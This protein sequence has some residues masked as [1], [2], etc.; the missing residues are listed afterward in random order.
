M[1][2]VCLPHRFSVQITSEP[3]SAHSQTQDCILRKSLN[4][5]P[6]HHKEKSGDMGHVEVSCV[7]ARSCACVYVFVCA[8]VCVQK[9]R[10][11]R[12]KAIYDCSADNPD[13]LTFREGEVIVVEGE[14][15]SEWWVSWASREDDINRSF[16]VT[17]WQSG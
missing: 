17:Q 3:G 2:F 8:C 11:Q 10:P 9:H 15:D 7:C 16:P 6:L 5:Q 14:E 13:E 4:T 1:V 12:V